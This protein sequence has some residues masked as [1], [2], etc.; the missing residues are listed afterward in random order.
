M[1]YSLSEI[2]NICKALKE[3]NPWESGIIQ[4]IKSKIKSHKVYKQ[5]HRCCYCLKN[6]RGEYIYDIDIEH[7]LP[8]SVYKNCIFDLENLAASC[9]RCNMKIKR[10]RVDFLKHD[11]QNLYGELKF[12]YFESDNYHII[13]PYYDDIDEHLELYELTLRSKSIK[14]YKYTS[15]KGQYTYN[16]FKMKELEVNY[17]DEAQGVNKEFLLDDKKM[18]S[19]LTVEEIFIKNGVN[20]F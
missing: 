20:I 10:A 4:S 16:Y 7:I 8:K 11:L 2:K 12:F 14:K 9:K 6:F 19:E 17:L 1:E 18:I 5:K 15:E 13:H 3:N